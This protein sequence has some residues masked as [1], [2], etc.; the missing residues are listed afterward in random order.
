MAASGFREGFSRDDSDVQE[1]LSCG[2]P[3][4]PVDLLAREMRKRFGGE[5]HRS[6]VPN[7]LELVCVARNV[8]LDELASTPELRTAYDEF[9]PKVRNIYFDFQSRKNV[10]VEPQQTQSFV[11]AHS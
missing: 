9:D 1:I 6:T 7:A 10:P 3:N 4:G 8:R 11:R 5:V 2:L